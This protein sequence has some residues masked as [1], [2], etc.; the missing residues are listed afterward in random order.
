MS[1]RE[2]T[3]SPSAAQVPSVNIPSAVIQINDHQKIIQDLQLYLLKTLQTTLDMQQLIDNFFARVSKHVA[4]SGVEFSGLQQHANIVSGNAA[5]HQLVYELSTGTEDVGELICHS[6]HRI[7]GTNIAILEAA[8]STL[9]YP[10][11]NAQHYVC[12]LHQA[13]TDALTKLGNR[14]SFNKTLD[15]LSAAAKRHNRPLSLLMIDIDHFKQINDHYGHSVGDQVIVEVAHNISQIA[16]DADCAFRYGGEEFVVVLDNTD[17][18]GAN[19]AAE[20][21]RE[22]VTKILVCE[23][24]EKP[25]SVSI[26]LASFHSND[27]AS[28]LVKRADV[29]LYHAKTK[30]RNRVCE[31]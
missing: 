14:H 5:V 2:L 23:N 4:L 16:R 6:K 29:A 8:A 28:S 13:Q 12:A 22:Q 26:G 9:V 30:G 19:I 20:R 25:L 21:L 10:L 18:Q 24:S 17:M 27:S 7:S 31:S 11:S 1:M 15:R 3:A